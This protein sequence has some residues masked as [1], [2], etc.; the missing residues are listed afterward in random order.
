MVIHNYCNM[1]KTQTNFYKLLHYFV[2]V[3]IWDYDYT[4]VSELLLNCQLPMCDL[5]ETT[6]AQKRVVGDC[7]YLVPLQVDVGQVLH[8]SDCSRDPPE[9]VLK[10]EQLLQCCLL[11][12]DTVRD[13]KEV[14]V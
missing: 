4:T 1:E 7:L 12:K 10:A 6:K 2:L 13:V 9:V 8:A 5:L 3:A 14:T 11:N